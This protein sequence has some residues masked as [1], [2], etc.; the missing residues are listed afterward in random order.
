MDGCRIRYGTP[1]SGV[2][3][4]KGGGRRYIGSIDGLEII[5]I[6]DISSTT[7]SNTQTSSLITST[8]TNILLPNYLTL[9]S[10]TYSLPTQPSSLT[11]LTQIHSP[12]LPTL[13]P[14]T[15]QPTNQ[16][17]SPSQ[18]WQPRKS[19]PSPKSPVKSSSSK[20]EPINTTSAN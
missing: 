17:N 15:H 4:L 20:H 5:L 1:L 9:T 19:S 14:T 8:P 11:T 3:R 13:P 6:F 12:H 10:T 18:K 2:V 16:P 7:N